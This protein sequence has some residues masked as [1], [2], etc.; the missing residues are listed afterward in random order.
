MG[1]RYPGT[2]PLNANKT[3]WQYRLKLTLPN[4]EKIDTTCKRNEHGHPF[5]TAEEAY[6]AKEAHRDRLLSG[7]K[8]HTSKQKEMTLKDLYEHYMSSAEAKSKAPSTIAKQESMWKNHISDKFGD[9]LF[10]DITLA[11]LQNYLHE[12]YTIK[13][14]EYKYVEG[15]LRFFYLLWGYAY[16]LD[17]VDY[18]RYIKMFIDRGTRLT[19]PEMTQEDSEEAEGPIETYNQYQI[20]EMEDLFKS[21]EGNLLTAFYLGLYCGL[22]ISEVFAVRWRSIDW[23]ESS[24]LINRQMHYE[25]GMLKLCPVKTMKSVRKVYMPKVLHNYLYDL[26]TKQNEQ[27]KALGRA[28]RNTERVYDTMLKEEITEGDFINRKANGELLTVNSMKYWSKKIKA[29]L[30]W[31][32][33]FHNLRHT[34]ASNCAANNMNLQML[35]EMMG[36]KKLETTKKYYISTNNPDLIKRTVDLL[37]TIYKSPD[38]IDTVE[39]DPRIMER[40]RKKETHIPRK[41]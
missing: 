24:I 27:K 14:Y 2:L 5:L 29:E 19:M 11:D 31:D 41:R 7:E 18:E 28:Y 36:H 15:F 40:K 22:R 4:G 32:F 17:K 12:L 8:K 35:M 9:D 16:R 1:R 37:N 3:A 26:Y 23:I 39:A 33:K 34:Y 21:E 10:K 6:K 30:G 38:E 13:G 20:N 25:G